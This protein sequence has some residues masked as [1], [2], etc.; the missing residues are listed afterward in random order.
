MRRTA[1]APNRSSEHRL[2]KSTDIDSP[3][4]DGRAEV[5]ELRRGVELQ[6]NERD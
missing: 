5:G 1:Y 6:S 2:T 3:L 4:P